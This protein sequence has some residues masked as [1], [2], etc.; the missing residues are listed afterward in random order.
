MRPDLRAGYG[1][2]L[3]AMEKY[4]KQSN[5]DVSGEDPRPAQGHGAR[6]GHF[7]RWVDRVAGPVLLWTARRDARKYPRG[8]DRADDVLRTPQLARRARKRNPL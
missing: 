1:A 7:T 4:L 2:A 8:S 3:F 5:A 6:A